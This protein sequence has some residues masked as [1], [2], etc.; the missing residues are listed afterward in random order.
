MFEILFYSLIWMFWLLLVEY[1]AISHCPKTPAPEYNDLHK[2]W[3]SQ[4]KRLKRSQIYPQLFVDPCVISQDKDIQGHC[5]Q[6]DT[7]YFDG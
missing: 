1:N 3:P 5:F 2:E 6:H 7:P 4:E